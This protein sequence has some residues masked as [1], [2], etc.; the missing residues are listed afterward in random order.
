ML[1]S[2]F[3]KLRERRRHKDGS[4]KMCGSNEMGQQ[5]NFWNSVRSARICFFFFPTNSCS[6]FYI[7]VYCV[8]V[9][10]LILRF[11]LLS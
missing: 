3:T 11:Q 1:V 5:A 9:I 8:I 6:S 4:N 10:M 7:N 2:F